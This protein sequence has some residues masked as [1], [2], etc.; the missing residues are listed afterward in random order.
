VRAN[1]ESSTTATD[2]SA[3]V[4]ELEQRVKQLERDV[5]ALLDAHAAEGRPLHGGG[6]VLRK[7]DQT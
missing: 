1:A 2:G 6:E 7:R 4:E 3:E 5:S